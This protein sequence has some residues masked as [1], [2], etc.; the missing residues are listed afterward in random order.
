MIRIE[1][2]HLAMVTTIAQAGTMTAA[3]DALAITQPALSKQLAQ[4]EAMLGVKLFERTAKSS[5]TAQMTM[6]LTRAGRRFE[7][8]ARKLLADLTDFDNELANQAGAATGRLRI[9]TDV[10][11]DD[12]R[13]AR[14]MRRFA[15][16]H[17]NMELDA[18]PVADP[19]E[20]L[21]DGHVDIAVVGE[22]PRR[23]GIRFAPI[24]EDE[25]VVVMADAHPLTARKTIAAVD[26]SGQE[27]VYHLDLERSILFRRYL[28]PANIRVGGFHRIESPAAILA[29]LAESDA[30]TLLPRRIVDA[31][32]QAASL[33]TRP[34]APDGYRFTWY[35]AT[36]SDDVRPET[37]AFVACLGEAGP[38]Q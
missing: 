8:R 21:A 23:A 37:Q 6:R 36:R 7:T 31:V 18:H 17:G 16:A 9:A 25:L 30:I 20:A 26:F 10:I 3:A 22:A 2:K 12:L 13:L 24:G 34:L 14:A 28:R 38:A 29:S 33:E 1:R 27:L 5:A 11:H 4:L 32:P 35:A 15:A 19:L